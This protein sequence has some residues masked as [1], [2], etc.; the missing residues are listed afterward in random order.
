MNIIVCFIK[1]VIGLFWLHSEINEWSYQEKHFSLDLFF[2]SKQ[3]HKNVS[4]LIIIFLWGFEI[5]CKCFLLNCC[6]GLLG[7]KAISII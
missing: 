1:G 6:L 3:Y 2:S 7:F 4:F 5:N